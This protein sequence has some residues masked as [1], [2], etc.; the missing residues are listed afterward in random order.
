MLHL[1]LLL[2]EEEEEGVVIIV[3]LAMQMEGEKKERMEKGRR[4]HLSWI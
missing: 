1:L 2:L 4:M 3:T